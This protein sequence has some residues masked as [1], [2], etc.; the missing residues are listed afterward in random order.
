MAGLK[1]TVNP[2]DKL[3]AANVMGELELLC[4]VDVTV[5]VP[6]P[7]IGTLIALGESAIVNGGGAKSTSK[8][9]GVVSVVLPSEPATVMV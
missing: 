8:V 3:P 4:A 9:T 2:V 7:P 1:F 6:V 5:T